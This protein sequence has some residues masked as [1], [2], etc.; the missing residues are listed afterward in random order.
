[1][2]IFVG[3]LKNIGISVAGWAFEKIFKAIKAARDAAKR[4]KERVEQATQ[5]KEKVK[6]AQTEEELDDAFKDQ[7][8]NF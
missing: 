8:D 6:T 3:I 7:F 1:M 5:A 4:D 2:G